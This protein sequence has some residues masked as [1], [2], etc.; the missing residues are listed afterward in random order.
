MAAPDRIEVPDGPGRMS[1]AEEMEIRCEMRRREREAEF[2]LQRAERNA[3][4]EADR[5]LRRESDLRHP[6]WEMAESVAMERF[7]EEIDRGL[8]AAEK[9]MATGSD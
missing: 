8:H 7:R 4:Y 5:V 1:W 2:A 6:D 3:R 9:I